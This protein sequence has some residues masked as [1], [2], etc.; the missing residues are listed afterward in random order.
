LAILAVALLVWLYQSSGTNYLPCRVKCILS[1]STRQSIYKSRRFQGFPFSRESFRR[2]PKH[3]HGHL[4]SSEH[5]LSLQ[6]INIYFFCICIKLQYPCFNPYTTI[7]KGHRNVVKVMTNHVHTCRSIANITMKI[8][9][10]QIIFP[11]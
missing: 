2:I 11:G 1:F 6:Y 5:T 8:S 9:V 10:H 7:I 3:S 4:F